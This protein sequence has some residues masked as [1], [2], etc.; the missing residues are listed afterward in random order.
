MNGQKGQSQAIDIFMFN[1]I[2]YAT[3]QGCR[4]NQESRE[5]RIVCI[6]TIF[7]MPLS[8]FVEPSLIRIR[9]KSGTED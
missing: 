4:K 8:F 3:Y 9:P 2:S 6:R 1:S 7:T 5:S